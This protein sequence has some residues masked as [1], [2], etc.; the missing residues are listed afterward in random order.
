MNFFYLF[1]CILRNLF[2]CFLLPLHKT[3]SFFILNKYL[4]FTSLEKSLALKYVAFYSEQRIHKTILQFKPFNLLVSG[5]LQ[6]QPLLPVYVSGL[7]HA[8]EITKPHQSV[9]NSVL[10]FRSLVVNHFHLTRFAPAR[11]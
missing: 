4:R 11:F 5:M 3:I 9:Q 2:V 10:V 6:R 7:R 1:S 8:V